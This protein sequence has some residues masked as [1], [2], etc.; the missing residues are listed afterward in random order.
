MGLGDLGVGV[1]KVSRDDRPRRPSLQQ[2]GGVGVAQD[3]E[4][5]RRIKSRSTGRPGAKAGADAIIPT[6]YR[7]TG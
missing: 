7:P 1:A 4:A 5:C 3:V 6:I 2:L